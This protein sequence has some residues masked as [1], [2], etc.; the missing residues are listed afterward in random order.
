MAKLPTVQTYINRLRTRCKKKFG[1]DFVA[2]NEELIEL[3][4]RNKRKLDRFE[5]EI[6]NDDLLKMQV[7]SNGQPK[8]DINPLVKYRNDIAKLYADNLD[9]L[10]LTPRAKFKKAEAKRDPKDNENDPTM[11]YFNAI[12]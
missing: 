6:D 9:A 3:A 12:K 2:D 10:Q 1:D 5:E 8:E 11:E 7:G 4:A